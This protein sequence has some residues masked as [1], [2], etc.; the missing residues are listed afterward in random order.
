MTFVVVAG[1]GAA[2][3]SPVLVPLIVGLSVGIGSVFAIWELVEYFKS[4]KPKTEAERAADAEADRQLHDDKLRVFM[5]VEH[6]GVDAKIKNRIKL[7]SKENV[8]S[9]A[10]LEDKVDIRSRL[11]GSQ[12]ERNA[13]VFTA[14]LR[15]VIDSIL[16]FSFAGWF[17]STGIGLVPVLAGLTAVIGSTAVQGIFGFAIGGLLSLKAGSKLRTEQKAYEEKV[18]AILHAEYTGKDGAGKTKQE[19]FENLFAAVEA[20]KQFLQEYSAKDLKERFKIKYDVNQVDVFNDRYFEK[21]QYETP[22]TT[23]FKKILSRVHAF[24]SGGQTGVFHSRFFFLKDGLFAGAIGAVAITSLSLG[25]AAIP[26]LILAGVFA[27]AFGILKV[28]QYQLE[29]NQAHRE[30]LYNTFDARISYLK[31]KNKELAGLISLVNES[32]ATV[33]PSATRQN[34][35]QYSGRPVAFAPT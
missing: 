6:E 3:A 5:K 32:S 1:F 25:P 4:P 18:D 7:L 29:R 17:L 24:F 23:V 13:R 31:K 34:D 2:I 20:K 28:V 27:V 14:G 30:N 9:F 10:K 12:A 19:A 15:G 35:E 26:F 16:F 22:G 11:L 21:F 33:A 8:S